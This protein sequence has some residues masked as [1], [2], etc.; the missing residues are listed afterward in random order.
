MDLNEKQRNMLQEIEGF[1]SNREDDM[2]EMMLKHAL[3]QINKSL[4]V[5][6][7]EKFFINLQ[8][9]CFQNRNYQNG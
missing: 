3:L 7:L 9:T 6:H 4:K 1:H 8:I 2:S 5:L